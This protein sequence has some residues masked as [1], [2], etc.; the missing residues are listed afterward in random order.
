MEMSAYVPHV[1]STTHGHPM[2]GAR[3]LLLVSLLDISHCLEYW[4]YLLRSENERGIRDDAERKLHVEQK[5][6]VM[7]MPMSK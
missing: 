6:N 7:C 3:Q 4:R 1:L 5:C 2:T